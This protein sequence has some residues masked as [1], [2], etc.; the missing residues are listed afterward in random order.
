MVNIKV[1]L[2][3]GSYLFIGSQLQDQCSP[4][5]L[6]FLPE[7][8]HTEFHRQIIFTKYQNG[9]GFMKKKHGACGLIPLGDKEVQ[10]KKDFY[11]KY[12]ETSTINM[13][14]MDSGNHLDEKIITCD[15]KKK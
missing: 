6:I 12:M 11:Y 13:G 5:G 3:S 10:L 4:G 14:N 15:F 9:T 2:S 1:F 8:K 7:G